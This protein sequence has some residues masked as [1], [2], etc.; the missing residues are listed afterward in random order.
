[1]SGNSLI[2]LGD[3]SKP[4]T[5]LIEKVSDAI[6][7]LAKPWQ[8]KRV[9][10]AEAEAEKIKA[11]AQIEISDIQQRAL[12]RMVREEGIRQNNIEAI[13]AGAIPHLKE[14]AKPENIDPDWLSHF[15]EK[16]RIVSGEEMQGLWSKILAGE[17]NQADTFSKRTVD[18]VSS[19][20][21]SDAEIFTRFCGCVFDFGG[22]EPVY[23]YVDANSA[24]DTQ[25]IPISFA[26][27]LHLESIG[28]IKFDMLSEFIFRFKSGKNIRVDYYRVP[29]I[30][31][32]PGDSLVRGHSSFTQSGRE[33]APICGS[34]PSR[35]YFE[36][37]LQKWMDQ[38]YA[39]S[40]PIRSKAAWTHW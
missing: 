37:V 31:D 39:I 17:A 19:I 15:F 11:L 23:W 27:L 16:S 22:L 35:N 30:I 40:A 5:V 32:L 38:G 13:T 34:S 14:D 4:A 20:S 3:L 24:P 29:L 8:V 12:V 36:S 2:N 1:M 26:E 10:S 6:G 18:L 33:L 9:A 7:G 25:V 28:L 21:K